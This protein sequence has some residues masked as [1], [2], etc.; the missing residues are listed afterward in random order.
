M[1]RADIER[2][3]GGVATS[4]IRLPEPGVQPRAIITLISQALGMST[5][6]LLGP[7]RDRHIVGARKCACAVLRGKGL[8]LSGIGRRLGIDHSSVSWHVSTFDAFCAD[9]PELRMIA[10]AL[11]P[12]RPIAAAAAALAAQQ[13]QITAVIIARHNARRDRN[14]AKKL[15]EKRARLLRRIALAPLNSAQ[16]IADAALKLEMLP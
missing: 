16:D 14:E 7:R 6:T 11:L 12:A 10:D 8:T 2:R 3:A 15:A 5:D 1:T 9:W 4:A 13:A